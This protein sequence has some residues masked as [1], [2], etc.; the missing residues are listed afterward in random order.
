MEETANANAIAKNNANAEPSFLFL[1][2]REAAD[3]GFGMTALVPFFPRPVA[4]SNLGAI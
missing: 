1:R 4:P 2:G 3:E